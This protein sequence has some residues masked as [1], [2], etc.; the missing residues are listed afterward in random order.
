[1]KSKCNIFCILTRFLN[2]DLFFDKTDKLTDHGIGHRQ[3][4]IKEGRANDNKCLQIVT[5]LLL[6]FK[7]QFHEDR[8]A[9]NPTCLCLCTMDGGSLLG[10]LQYLGELDMENE[11]NEEKN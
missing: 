8:S 10:T 6:Y 1:M 11:R 7:C 5:F 2:T 9:L 3:C 4:I